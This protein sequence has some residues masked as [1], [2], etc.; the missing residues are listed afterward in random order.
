MFLKASDCVVGPDDTV[1]IPRGSTK[2]DYEV[3]LTVVLGGRAHYLAD[4]K[5]VAP[6]IAGYCLGNDV[7]ERAWQRGDS[8]G[9]WMKGKSAPT[10]APLGPWLLTSDEVPDPQ[11]LD[12]KTWVNGELRQNG[13]TADMLFGVNHLVW[14]ASQ[15]LALE[16]GDVI[17]TGTPA[18]VTLGRSDGVFL[19]AGDVVEMEIEKLGRQRQVLANA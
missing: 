12:L 19:K 15:H 18:G 3:E 13:N 16:P 2:M 1:L 11:A 7:S 14:Y 5:A 9:Q 4:E 17:M 8:G 6:L 10:F